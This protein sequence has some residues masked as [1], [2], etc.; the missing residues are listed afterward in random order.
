[1]HLGD[2]LEL[3][4]DIPDS[5]IDM[6]LCDLPYGTTNIKGWDKIIPAE[7]MW[8]QYNRI[9]KEDGSIVLFGSQPFTS[10][11]VSSNPKMFRYEW[12]WNK[13]KGA[14]FLNSNCQ[15]LKTHEN[16][17]V[18]SKLPA[19]PNKKGNAKY[20]PQKTDLEHEY[21]Y[22]DSEKTRN[23]VNGGSTAGVKGR[24]L[25]GKH[26]TS[27][28]TFKKDGK[29]HPTQKPVELCEHLIKTYTDEGD[30]VL[31]SCI[32]SGTTAIAAINTNRKWIGIEMEKE[33]IDVSNK[34]II[35]HIEALNITG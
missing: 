6:I 23:N 19:S 4:K 30:I 9:I 27:I 25:K 29:L 33:Y 34:R 35:E 20:N 11:L 15:P 7:K 18:F 21:S 32:G 1:M 5:S 31:D 14:N 8:E 10:F 24:T 28:Q 3:M 13:T 26:P 22:S 2:C 12:I 17:L 16:I